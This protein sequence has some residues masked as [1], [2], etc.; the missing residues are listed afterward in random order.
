[1]T[2]DIIIIVIFLILFLL[3]VTLNEVVELKQYIKDKK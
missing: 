3:I 2:Q 1:M